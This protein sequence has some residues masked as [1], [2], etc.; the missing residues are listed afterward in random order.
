M[1]FTLLIVTVGTAVFLADVGPSQ[2]TD[3]ADMRVTADVSWKEHFVSNLKNGEMAPET[4]LDVSLIVQGG[5]T[6]SATACGDL[7]IDS[8]QDENGQRLKCKL[9]SLGGMVL[10]S[11]E[12]NLDPKDSVRIS[13]GLQNPPALKK[14]AELRGSFALRTGGHLQEVI[15]KDLLKQSGPVINDATLKRLGVTVRIART[16]MEANVFTLS[17]L[18]EAGDV[19]DVLELDVGNGEI[20]VGGYAYP[21]PRELKVDMNASDRCAV[22]RLTITDANGKPIMPLRTNSSYGSSIGKMKF[23]FKEKLPD[24]SQLHLTI[25]R[26]AKNIRVPFGLTN[27]EVPRRN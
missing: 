14:L 3:P 6:A 15:V 9:T 1:K 11:Q 13:F 5:V 22:T 4:Y 8:I 20:P 25:H 2:A 17:P 10:V 26:D 21:A 23:C 16:T 12:L 27:I 24:G 7:T 19:Q 18:S